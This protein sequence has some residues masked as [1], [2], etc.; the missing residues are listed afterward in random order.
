VRGGIG[1]PATRRLG[2]LAVEEGIE[3]E[4]CRGPATFAG[5]EGLA[6]CPQLSFAIFEQPQRGANDITGRPVAARRDLAVDKGAVMLV[7]TEGCVLTH[8]PRVPIIGIWG[9][10][11]APVLSGHPIADAEAQ[12]IATRVKDWIDGGVALSEIGISVRAKWLTSKIESAL[13][14]AGIGSIDLAKTSD[15][16]DAVRVLGG[17]QGEYQGVGVRR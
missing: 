15:D 7:E 3:V 4:R 9:T 2:P 16:D 6:Q 1:S 11:L 13:R 5:V 8:P 12:F 17:I 14:K 10:G